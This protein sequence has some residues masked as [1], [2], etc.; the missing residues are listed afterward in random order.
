MYFNGKILNAIDFDEVKNIYFGTINWFYKNG[1]IKQISTYN[2]RGLE[3]GISKYYYESGKIAK[4]I[5]FLNGKKVNNSFLEYDEDGISTKI[6]E[7]DYNDNSSEWDLYTN[8]KNSSTIKNG[9]FELT[10]FTKEGRS[11]YINHK[12][13]SDEFVIEAIINCKDQKKNEKA[14]ILFGFKDWDNYHYFTISKNSLFVGSVYEGVKSIISDCEFCSV[15]NNKENNNI[16]IISK[17][18]KFYFSVNGEIQYSNKS[19]KLFGYN[20]GFVISGVSKLKVDKLIIK[21][22]GS[23]SNSDKSKSNEDKGV[24]ATGSGIIFTTNGLIITNYH[25]IEN[26][27]NLTVEI[28]EG[29]D[30]KNYKTEILYKD[31]ENDLAIIKISDSKFNVLSEIMYSFKETG[32]MDVGAAAF[33]IGFPFALS[34][35]GKEAKFSDGKISA[36]SGYNGAINSMQTTIPVQPG[37]SGGPVF[38]WDGQLIGVINATI[39]NADNVSYI[40]K[41]NY[42]KNLIESM[43]EKIDYPSNKT[44]INLPLEEKIKVIKKYVVL[45][46]VK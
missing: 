36:K 4:E 37:N 42:I 45:I 9:N 44:I 2:E 41:L 31:K 10:S 11:R 40:I 35:M 24:K 25:V 8:L 19:L 17:D 29:S 27:N 5:E 33:T 22:L 6:F 14:G 43:T 20:F 16:K 18:D 7:D 46:K 38:N 12:I 26:A 3:D 1:N 30:K 15:I 28:E 13:T 21:E 32:S 39:K 34:G 23:F